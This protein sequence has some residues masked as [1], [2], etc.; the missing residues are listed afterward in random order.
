MTTKLFQSLQVGDYV[1]SKATG[2]VSVVREIILSEALGTA[3]MVTVVDYGGNA[4]TY[5][6][7]EIRLLRRSQKGRQ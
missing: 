5:D 4:E 1:Q 2:R 3:V 6:R 7:S